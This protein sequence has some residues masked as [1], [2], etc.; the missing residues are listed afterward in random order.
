MG[1]PTEPSEAGAAAAGSGEPDFHPDVQRVAE[2][3][4]RLKADLQKLEEVLGADL[5]EVGWIDRVCSILGKLEV[6][7]KEHFALEEADPL[8]RKVPIQRP[9]FA[10]KLAALEAEHQEFIDSL[11]GL[12][13][14]G[15]PAVGPTR[16]ARQ[17][18]VDAIHALVAKL[19]HHE[20]AET[21][22][23]LRVDWEDLG[24]GD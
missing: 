5:L 17:Q 22:I 15:R 14:S 6:D 13:C 9:R 7:L 23:M 10:D 24:D 1:T 8:Y 18:H 12:I 16:E 21:D 19:R 20:A 4:R 11:E 2:D 3:H